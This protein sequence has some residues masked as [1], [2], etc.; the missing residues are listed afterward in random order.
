MN[1]LVELHVTCTAAGA[2]STRSAFGEWLAPVCTGKI[3]SLLIVLALSSRY[4]PA[5]LWGVPVAK[6]PLAV[7]PGRTKGTGGVF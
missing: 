7:S 2:F 1:R 5:R 4:L 6:K 3:A